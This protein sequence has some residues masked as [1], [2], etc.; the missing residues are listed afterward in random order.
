VTARR[1]DQRAFRA[2][3]G[4][5]VTGIAV[6]TT[7]GPNGKPEGLTANSFGALS[8]DPP[9]V[10]WCLAKSAQSLPAFEICDYFAINVLGAEQ[11]PLSHQFA[12]RAIDKFAGVE[13]TEGLGGAPVFA[14]CLARFECRH[15]RRFDGG[16]HVIFVGHVERFA[17]ADG[18]PLLFNG[19]RYGI[20]SAHPDDHGEAVPSDDFKDLL[21]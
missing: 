6:V 12:T 3:L 19:G 7:R 17:H 8:L 13:W 5:F 11:R 15:D 14:G 9:L 21:L 20:A 1:V 2:A 18:E 10:L 16:D 4:R